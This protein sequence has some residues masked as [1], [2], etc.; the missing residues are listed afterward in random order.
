MADLF[1]SSEK[2]D[3]ESVFDD[4]HDTFGRSLIAFKDSTKTIIST[5][6]DFNYLYNNVKGDATKTIKNVTQYKSIK[7]RILYEDKQRETLY[8]AEANAQIKVD[9]PVG[10][11]R[12]KVDKD[13]YD[14]LKDS[15]RIELDGKVFVFDSDVRPF[16][17]FSPKYYTFYLRLAE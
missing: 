10:T 13:G 15:K 7:A 6:A 4:L 3:L 2:S 5:N 17:L 8:D 14:Y 16:G 11:V 1:T 9:R 12:L